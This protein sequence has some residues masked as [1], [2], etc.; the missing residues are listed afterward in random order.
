MNIR[1]CL[2]I[3]VGF[4]AC[5]AKPHSSNTPPS[6]QECGNAGATDL[7]GGF[8]ANPGAWPWAVILGRPNKVRDGFDVIC[9]GTLI[10]SDTVLT[11]A[12]C[13]DPA[14]ITHVRLGE[15]N[16]FTTTDG[17]NQVD[18]SIASWIHHP[19]YVSTTLDNDIAIVKLSQPVILNEHI[20]P[21][22]L[23]DAYQG[24]DLATELAVQPPVV[25]GWGNHKMYGNYGGNYVSY[26]LD[27]VQSP[28]VPNSECSEAYSKIDVAIDH[29]KMCT[30]RDL[31]QGSGGGGLLSNKKGGTWAVVGITS[32]GVG[33]NRKEFPSVFTRVDKYLS[34]I[35]EN[36]Y[37]QLNSAH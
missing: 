19:G 14:R 24:L 11:A 3:A 20:R 33:C 35:K 6:P 22:C 30:E 37:L 13:D 32:S 34:W 17:A 36:S 18:I 21:A 26:V 2:L 16:I 1:R 10:N 9:G 5:C 4:T 27:Q 8:E 23:P 12:S 31:C 15:H 7:T 29:T 25:V 28:V